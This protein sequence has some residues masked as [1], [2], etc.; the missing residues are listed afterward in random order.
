VSFYPP[1]TSL[2]NKSNGHEL[3]T[4]GGTEN[5]GMALRLGH[6]PFSVLP[7]SV[8]PS[9]HQALTKHGGTEKGEKLVKPSA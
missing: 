8:P 5:G 3:K 2:G 1:R 7:F 9:L 4:H 6:L